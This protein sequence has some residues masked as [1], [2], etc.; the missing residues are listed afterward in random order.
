MY[1]VDFVCSGN[2]P[3]QAHLIGQKHL[4]NVQRNSSTGTPQPVSTA[5]AGNSLTHGLASSK[6]PSP[7]MLD[8][9]IGSLHNKQNNIHMLLTYQ[10]FFIVH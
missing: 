1:C 8:D 7:I 10:V 3:L 9:M 6:S 5:S 2:V 4:K